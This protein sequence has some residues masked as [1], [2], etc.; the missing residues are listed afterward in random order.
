MQAHKPFLSY[1]GEWEEVNE[2]VFNF[3]Y[4]GKIQ[5]NSAPIFIVPPIY[6]ITFETIFSH[7]EEGIKSVKDFLN[8]ILFPNSH[9]ILDIQSFAPNTNA[10]IAKV[11]DQKDKKEKEII[12]DLELE[13][14]F[15][16]FKN[17][18][19]YVNGNGLKRASDSLEKW[20]IF[21]YIGNSKHPYSDKG[22]SSHV[23]KIYN[24]KDKQ[25][26]LNYIKIYEIYLNQLNEKINTNISIFQNEIIQKKERN[27]LGYLLLHYGLDIINQKK[28]MFYLRI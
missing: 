8:S 20:V 9:S 19:L 13:E 26:T 4:A 1:T 3:T 16:Y 21:L 15:T 27:G 7:D 12:I 23:I 2:E 5:M 25:D 28:F 11:K 18:K 14:N 24:I 6:N 10:F 22:S 17:E